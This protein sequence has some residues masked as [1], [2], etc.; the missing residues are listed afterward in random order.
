MSTCPGLEFYRPLKTNHSA[1]ASQPCNLLSHEQVI[2]LI[3]LFTLNLLTRLTLPLSTCKG[4]N[5]NTLG[6]K[7][8][9]GQAARI[10]SEEVYGSL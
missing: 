6:V 8:F 10:I 9:L 2:L 5:Y 1:L 3:G 4:L 7:L